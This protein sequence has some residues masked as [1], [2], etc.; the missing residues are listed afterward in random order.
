[1]RHDRELIA[2]AK[3]QKLETI[4]DRL[5]R[6]PAYVLKR[7]ARLGLSIKGRTATKK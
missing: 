7:A 5:Q 6:T 3:S 1:M 2:L 4:A